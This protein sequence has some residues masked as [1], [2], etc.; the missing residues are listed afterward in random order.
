MV[1]CNAM[2]ADLATCAA[3]EAGERVWPGVDLALE[4]FAEWVVGA[5]I[6][7]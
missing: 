7:A 6:K 1:R 5:G 2:Q 3:F 4:I